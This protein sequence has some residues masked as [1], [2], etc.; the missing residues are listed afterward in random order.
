MRAARQGGAC[1]CGLIVPRSSRAW[2]WAW[3]WSMRPIL[4]HLGYSVRRLGGKRRRRVLLP[5]SLEP[6]VGSLVFAVW[7]EI[8]FD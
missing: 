1:G 5:P 4:A 8:S 7:I 3:A 2:A 6:V